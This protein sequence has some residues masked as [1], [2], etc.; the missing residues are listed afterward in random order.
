MLD[1][2]EKFDSL[3]KDFLSLDFQEI[4][5]DNLVNIFYQLRNT[6]LDIIDTNRKIL[7]GEFHAS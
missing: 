1:L 5:D 7:K 2:I 3:E 6:S 4:Q